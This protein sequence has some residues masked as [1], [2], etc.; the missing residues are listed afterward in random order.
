LRY[1]LATNQ[2]LQTI[3]KSDF[4]CPSSLLGKVT[5]EMIKRNLFNGLIVKMLNQRF[6]SLPMACEIL[7]CEKEDLIQEGNT[8]IWKSVTKFKQGK[9][10]FAYYCSIHLLSLFRDM[11]KAIKSG[12]REVVLSSCSI[13]TPIGEDLTI[14]DVLVYGKN[15]ENIVINKIS[16]EEKLSVLNEKEKTTISL[17]AK[18]YCMDEIAEIEHISKSG[19]SRRMKKITKKLSGKEIDLS[20]LGLSNYRKGA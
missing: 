5:E 12:K 1:D 4:N 3:V 13:H 10:S 14:E 16:L 7:S 18:G 17:Y 11:E 6:S 9:S 8:E 2:Q 20:S 19:V 15:T